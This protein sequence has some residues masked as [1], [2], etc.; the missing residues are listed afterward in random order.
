VIDTG[1][2]LLLSSLRFIHG[3]VL[4]MALVPFVAVCG[5]EGPVDAHRHGGASLERQ[6]ACGHRVRRVHPGGVGPQ[7]LVI[8]KT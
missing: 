3:I 5:R 1:K 6:E 4:L 7:E 2:Q 8:L